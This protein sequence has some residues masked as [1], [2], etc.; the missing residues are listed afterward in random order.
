MKKNQGMSVVKGKGPEDIASDVIV[1]VLECKDGKRVWNGERY[2]DFLEFLQSVAD[3]KISALVR[4][5]EN[6]ETRHVEPVDDDDTSEEERTFVFKEA[7]P[8]Q[9]VED[10]EWKENFREALAN[11]LS[12]DSISL[13]LFDC[14]DA[15]FK[16]RS[17]IAAVLEVSVNDVYNAQKR[18]ER[19]I[20]AVMKKLE[21]R[22]G[23]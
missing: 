18:L 10:A 23:K 6:R 13:G 3:S 22:S 19:K 14:L 2:P 4:S 21:D 16:D 5:K 7:G 9:L 11:E 8:D 20:E 1:A 17:E 15:G 12:D